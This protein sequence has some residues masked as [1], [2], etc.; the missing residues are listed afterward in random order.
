MASDYYAELGVPRGASQD[1]IKKAYRKAAHQHHPDKSGG[2]EARFKRVNE[3]Y[4]VLGNAEKRAR[5][6]RTGS[7]DA[8]P[9]FGGGSGGFSGFGG[10]FNAEG[11]N[12]EDLGDLFSSV[13]T[14]GFGGSVQR[15]TKGDDLRVELRISLE[16][17]FKGGEHR[18]SLPTQVACETC[19][20][21][22]A[23]EG[24]K[25]V[26][27]D[28]CKGKGQVS[29]TRRMIFGQFQQTVPCPT[30]DGVGKVPEKPCPSCSGSGRKKG[31]RSV[32][33]SFE[34]GIEDGQVIA[35]PGMGEAGRRGQPAGN[36][37]VRIRV[38]PHAR[39]ER[40]GA[41]LITSV[42]VSPLQLLRHDPIRV[43]GIDGKDVT[44]ELG[45]GVDLSEAYR[46]KGEGMPRYRGRGHGDLYVRFSVVTGKKLGKKER[47][48]LMAFES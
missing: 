39:F 41:D 1:E 36:L 27:C 2:D 31:Q 45:I 10:G 4:Q 48:A 34:P 30:C 14:G 42:R 25:L 26:T 12:V 18:F 5:Y 40:H 47:E 7:A 22:G 33:V 43:P 21:D 17:S 29:Q 9:G 11:F 16:D 15:E 13:F 38:A 35:V 19:K 20:G 37:G 6:D 3:A 24:S 44:V 23:A 32:A 8:G 28:T 46:V